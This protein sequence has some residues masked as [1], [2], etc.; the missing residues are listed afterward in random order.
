MHKPKVGCTQSVYVSHAFR[1]WVLRTVYPDVTYT[2]VS[3]DADGLLEV[4]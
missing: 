1:T 2:N 3:S 4:R